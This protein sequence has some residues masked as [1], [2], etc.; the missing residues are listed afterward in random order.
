MTTSAA[1]FDSPESAA[2]FWQFVSRI[3]EGELHHEDL[4][5]H[6]TAGGNYPADL[7]V[8]GRIQ[9]DSV[10]VKIDGSLRVVPYEELWFASRKTAVRAVQWLLYAFPGGTRQ[11]LV[12]ILR[13]CFAEDYHPQALAYQSMDAE[14]LLRELENLERQKGRPARRLENLA[15]YQLTR[16]ALCLA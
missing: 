9:N 15:Q 11:Q 7:H 8:L 10:C 5:Q 6:L 14:A 13:R 1:L 3:A 16:S 12:A 4:R 2:A